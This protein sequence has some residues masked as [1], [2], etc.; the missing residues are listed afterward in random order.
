M[1][2]KY[3][4]S[5]NIKLEYMLNAACFQLPKQLIIVHFMTTRTNNQ[6]R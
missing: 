1:I 3:H 6:V 2:I 5:S 4:K